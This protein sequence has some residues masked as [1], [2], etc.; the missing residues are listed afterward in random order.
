MCDVGKGGRVNSFLFTFFTVRIWPYF[1]VF[2][3]N[4]SDDFVYVTS[5]L[6]FPL[7]DT[8]PLVLQT[9]YSSPPP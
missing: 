9:T 8:R 5:S 1:N 4:L 3:C 2:Y 6:K 7:G